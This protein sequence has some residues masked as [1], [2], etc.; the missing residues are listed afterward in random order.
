[1]CIFVFGVTDVCV[2]YFEFA[3]IFF[4]RRLFF[5]ALSASPFTQHTLV[6]RDFIDL[7]RSVLSV[8]REDPLEPAA[9]TY[10]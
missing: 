8:D 6:G 3:T 1:M 5:I 2:E 9:R 4:M 7:D 10:V